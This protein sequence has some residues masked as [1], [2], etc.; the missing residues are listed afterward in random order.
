VD[1]LDEEANWSFETA[2]LFPVD[3]VAD[4]G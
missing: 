1:P 2:D 4:D 3:M